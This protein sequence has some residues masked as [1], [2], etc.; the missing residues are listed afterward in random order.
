[1]LV[2]GWRGCER[3]W[4]NDDDLAFILHGFLDV[5]AVDDDEV[6]V[7]QAKDGRR[8]KLTV[9]CVWQ[10]KRSL[11]TF[12][13]S[14]FPVDT[15]AATAASRIRHSVVVVTSLAF[16]QTLRVLVVEVD[17]VLVYAARVGRRSTVLFRKVWA[18]NRRRELGAHFAITS[19]HQLRCQRALIVQRIAGL[20]GDEWLV[21][22]MSI[23][24]KLRRWSDELFES[25]DQVVEQRG[26]RRRSVLLLKRLIARLLEETGWQQ[27]NCVVITVGDVLPA[28][29]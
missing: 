18:R 6:S 1:M 26:S 8:T 2:V 13:R 4:V 22:G 10:L 23:G 20:D 17:E 12:W 27:E 25:A 3:R 9:W 21:V 16:F 7:F 28:K 19:I 15:A 11:L 5:L 14:V 29:V 24:R